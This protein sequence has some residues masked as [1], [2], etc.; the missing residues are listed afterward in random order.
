MTKKIGAGIAIL[1]I[2]IVVY[3]MFV[4][5]GENNEPLVKEQTQERTEAEVK[6]EAEKKSLKDLAMSGKPQKCEFKQAVEN[7][8]SSGTYFI[9]NGKVRGD[10]SISSRGQN[11]TGHMLMDGSSV[12]SWTDSQK[13][14]FRMEVT[15]ET[16]I[17][18]NQNQSVNINQQLNYNCEDWRVDES[19]FALPKDITFKS[20][21]DISAEASSEA[22][23]PTGDLKAMQCK[24]CDNVPAE[25]RAQ[26]RAALSCE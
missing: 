21:A 8:E 10:Y 7:S 1:I 3:A 9:S 14:G 4:R 6:T 24:A 23:A 13:Q 19:V 15:G 20:I 25:S 22:N 26:C 17:N 2:A 16:D 12:Y 11:I 18:T 5:G